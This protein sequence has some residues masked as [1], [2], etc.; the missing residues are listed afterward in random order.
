MTWLDPVGVVIGL[1]IAV[2]VLW[3]W[4]EIVVGKRR[5]ERRWYR[6]AGRRPGQRP[7]ILIVDLLT[8]KN[9]RTS[10]EHFRQGHEALRQIPADRIVSV[11]HDSRIAPDDMPELARKI[12]R[13]AADLLA[14]GADTIHLFYAGPTI[15]AAVAGAELANTA[16]V[17]VYQHEPGEYR[18]FGPLRSELP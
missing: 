1:L 9:I 2:P 6:E 5:R 17:I 18:N 16:R 12:R 10:V 15:V 7:A 4:Y 14:A 13:A 8:G 3:T 11:N